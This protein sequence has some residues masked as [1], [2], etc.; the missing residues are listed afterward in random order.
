MY[1]KAEDIENIGSIEVEGK[2]FYISWSGVRWEDPQT[3]H[4]SIDFYLIEQRTIVIEQDRTRCVRVNIHTKHLL[5]KCNSENWESGI[6]GEFCK[7]FREDN[8]VKTDFIKLLKTHL[9]DMLEHFKKDQS[10]Y[11]ISLQET[12]KIF[13]AD[14]RIKKTRNIQ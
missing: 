13:T 3:D 4:V 12:D 5:D 7:I 10:P 1:E 9:I 11:S 2:N 6:E 14:Y 8:R